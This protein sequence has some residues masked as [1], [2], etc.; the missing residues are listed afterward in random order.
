MGCL[1]STL[2][3]RTT[4]NTQSL[5]FNNYKTD[6]KIVDVYDGD[7]CKG[8]FEFR[9]KH[10][11]FKFRLAHIDT[12]EMRTTN[13][14]EK[15]MAIIARDRLR[16]LILD[17]IVYVECGNYDKYGRILATIYLNSNVISGTKSVNQI[18]LDEK[19]AVK[20]EGDKKQ[21]FK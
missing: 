1:Y 18:M 16:T 4:K 8:I 21:P 20:Y 7:T 15:E 19:L 11:I 5:N 12:P 9:G 14:K 13:A 2:Q 3:S 17:K 10:Y 6:C